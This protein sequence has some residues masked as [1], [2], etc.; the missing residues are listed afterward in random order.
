MRG[1]RRKLVVPGLL[2]VVLTVLL[3]ACS[4]SNSTGASGGGSGLTLTVA[5]TAGPL[6]RNFNPFLPTSVAL[7]DNVVSFIYEPLVQYNPFKP[8]APTPWLATA[9]TWS[10]GDKTLTFTLRKGV[11]WSD[12]QPF[13]SADVVETFDLIKQYPALNTNG[14]T[15]ENVAAQGPY[16]VTFQFAEPAFSQFYF[17]AGNT[18]IVPKHIWS[19]I[20]SP[21]KYTDPDPIGTGPY[22]LG[23]FSTQGF[24][25]NRNDHYWQGKPAVT[26]LIFPS[27][28]GNGPADAAVEDGQVDWAGQFIPDIKTVYLDKSPSYHSWSPAT[29]QVALV[30]NDSV[31]P[32]NQLPVREAI[33]L[34]LNRQYIA[35]EAESQQATAVQTQTGILA[36]ESEFIAPQYRGLNY[37]VNIAKAKALLAQA[38]YKPGSGGVLQK[39][40]QPLALTIVDD[41]GYT[42]YMTAAQIISQEL[43]AIGMDITVSGVSNN[44]WTSDLTDGKFQ[45]SIDYSNNEGVDPYAVY[46]GWLDSSLLQKGYAAGDYGRWN[47]PQTQAYISDYLKATTATARMQAI[48]GLEGI[49]VKD[50]PVIPL[51]GGPDWTEYSTQRVTGWPTASNPYDPAA[52]FSPNNEVVILR[53]KPRNS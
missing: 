8:Q 16:Q 24:Q 29:S 10:N 25:L 23:N 32:L 36:N 39:N 33:S 42:D 51:Y 38:G 1:N 28:N 15:F 49:M 18:Y 48:Y 46:S 43:K 20:G 4:S 27:Y 6:P 11:K 13:T 12:G 41:S 3:G 44:A 53:L 22:T 30:T 52:P 50:L 37:Q 31:A 14:V 19:T 34:A 21:L 9:W 5:S 7:T 45:L 26:G 17:L 35:S 40:G 2:A 47:D